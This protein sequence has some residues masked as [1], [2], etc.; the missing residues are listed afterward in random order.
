MRIASVVVSVLFALTL[1]ACAGK[2]KTKPL[3]PLALG[4][5]AQASAIAL[6]QQGTTA[7]HS[8]QFMEAKTYFRQAVAAAPDSGPAHYNLALALNALGETEEARAHFIEAANLAP[9]DKVIW[10]SPALRPYGSPESKKV[11]KEPQ[12]SYTRPAFGQVGPR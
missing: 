2:E 12:N 8:G 11:V 3:V 4:A 1:E 7:Y 10:D 6:T 5:G 9:G